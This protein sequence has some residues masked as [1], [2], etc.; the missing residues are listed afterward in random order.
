[1]QSFSP[2]HVSA[3]GIGT[4]WDQNIMGKLMDKYRKHHVKHHEKKSRTNQWIK[5]TT[6]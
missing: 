6:L 4:P 3:G 2:C 1:V 5:T